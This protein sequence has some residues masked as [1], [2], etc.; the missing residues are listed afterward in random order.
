MSM[1]KALDRPDT[2]AHRPGP[3]PSGLADELIC[4]A[5]AFCRARGLRLTPLRRSLL[6]MLSTTSEPL[7]AYQLCKLL[8]V[9]RPTLAPISVYRAL[10]F[11]CGLEIVHR[12]AAR[13]GYVASTARADDGVLFLVCHRC[14][15]ISEARSTEFKR[16]LDATLSLSGFRALSR[17][18]E[19]EGECAGC[20]SN[21]RKI[22]DEVVAR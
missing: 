10:D 4:R 6:H 8:A 2:D 18:M 17:P 5:E 11:L 3:P 9:A 14:G 22:A 21:G 20:Q 16:D 7:G 15:K 1:K 12:I 19:I 13:N